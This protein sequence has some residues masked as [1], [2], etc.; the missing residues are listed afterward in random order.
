ML[1]PSLISYMGE[2]EATETRAAE[3]VNKN[4]I[5][6]WEI[7]RPSL[8]DA[9]RQKNKTHPIQISMHDLKGV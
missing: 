4:V 1:G 5:L 7:V 6:G 8:T 3:P 9:T 2:P